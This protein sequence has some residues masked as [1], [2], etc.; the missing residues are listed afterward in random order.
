M[1]SDPAGFGVVRSNPG[2]A[3]FCPQHDDAAVLSHAC[4]EVICLTD[5]CVVGRPGACAGGLDSIPL[6][7]GGDVVIADPTRSPLLS[8]L[9]EAPTHRDSTIVSGTLVGGL[10]HHPRRDLGA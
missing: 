5:R 2:L 3:T 4:A 9:S 1:N 7:L 6:G 10:F 8:V